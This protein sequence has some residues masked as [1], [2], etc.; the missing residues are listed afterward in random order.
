MMNVK[1]TNNNVDCNLNK[2]IN[3]GIKKARKIRRENDQ[4]HIEYKWKLCDFK[5]DHNKRMERLASQ[6][7]YRLYEGSGK[8][9]YNLGYSD[10]G[11]PAGI[12]YDM[13]LRSLQ[14]LHTICDNIRAILKTYRVF[15]GLNGYCANVFIE[16]T[17]VFDNDTLF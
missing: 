2:K 16:G 8:A 17:S 13:M 4:G 12:P 7:K 3:H 11:E 9:V 6:L 5:N 10:N 15:Q 14:N 1:N